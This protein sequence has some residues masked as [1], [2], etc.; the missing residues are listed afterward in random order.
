MNEFWM[1]HSRLL[2][3]KNNKLHEECLRIIYSF[4]KL[5]FEELLIQDSSLSIHRGNIQTFAIKMQKFANDMSPEITNEIFSFRE[6][7]H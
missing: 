7:N 1:F 5:N 2:D 3:N 6:I 4:K